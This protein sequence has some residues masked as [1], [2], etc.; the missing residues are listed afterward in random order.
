LTHYTAEYKEWGDGPPLVLVPGMAGG[1]DLLGPV[2]K[3]LSKNFRVISYQLRGEDNCFA[4]RRP[5]GLTDLAEDLRE[6]MDYLCLETPLVFGVS[7]GAAVALEMA[8]RYPFRIQQLILQGTGSRYEGGLLPRV[9]KTVLNRFPLP[10]DNSFINQFFN[11]LFGSPTKRDALFHF[12]TRQCWQT[13]Q[14]M[15][16]YRLK[17]IEDF[18]V[19]GRLA[20]MH[21]PALL[22]SGERDVLVSKKS[23]TRL[24]NGL[25]QAK[26]VLLPGCGHL[27][28]VTNPDLITQHVER[29]YR[30]EA[31]ELVA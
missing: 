13:D 26:T 8:V 31:G 14:S 25:P 30:Q 18:N 3:A 20:R 24:A 19:E 12:V 1:I 16:A 27:A 6:F 2:A 5:F 22:L 7:F 28:F 23:L 9:A 29:F 11:V 15:M 17:L 4:L 10:S 21:R